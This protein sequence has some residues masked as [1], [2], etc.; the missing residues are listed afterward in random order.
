ME[1]LGIK[2]QGVNASMPPSQMSSAKFH[3]SFIYI[4]GGSMTKERL[5]S[6]SLTVQ[7]SM[8]RHFICYKFI[9]RTIQVDTV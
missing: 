4:C 9:A 1:I 5:W 7:F 3:N 6:I 2:V 8:F